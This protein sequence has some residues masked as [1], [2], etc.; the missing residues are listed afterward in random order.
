MRRGF[1]LI[2]LIVVVIIV[3]ILAT[4]AL[5]QYLKAAE[6]ARGA[7][8]KHAVSLIAQAEEM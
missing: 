6:R 3:A 1:T 4:F 5:P 7:K 2:E 8:A